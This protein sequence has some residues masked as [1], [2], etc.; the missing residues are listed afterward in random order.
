MRRHFQLRGRRQ[1][2][3][4]LMGNTEIFLHFSIA[5]RRV[6]MLVILMNLLFCR[7]TLLVPP[8]KRHLENNLRWIALIHAEGSRFSQG[9]QG[10]VLTGWQRYDHFAVLCELLP[11]SI[12]SL[13]LSLNSASRGYFEIDSKMNNLMAVLTCAEQPYK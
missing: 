7:E 11:V 6:M 10:L 9:I 13:A 5:P 1:L 8:L 2:S 12:P 4:E 3:K